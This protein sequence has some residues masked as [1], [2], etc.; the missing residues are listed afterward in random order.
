MQGNE[1]CVVFFCYF[2]GKW[3]LFCSDSFPKPFYFLC[4]FW[5]FNLW[6][7]ILIIESLK[8]EFF[9]KTVGDAFISYNNNNNNRRVGWNDICYVYLY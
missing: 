8:Y 3:A 4:I 1:Q 6:D 9:K 5:D 2:G 7:Y